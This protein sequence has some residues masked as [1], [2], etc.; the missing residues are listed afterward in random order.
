MKSPL[1]GLLMRIVKS[2]IMMLLQRWLRPQRQRPS[3]RQQKPQPQQKTLPNRPAASDAIIQVGYAPKL[4][5]DPDPGEVVWTWVTYEED[6]SRGKDRP[7]LIIGH[8]DQQLACVAL[9]SKRH[10][11]AAQ[12]DVGT[13]PWDRDRRV[14]YASIDRLLDVAPE[15]I[16]REGAIL[17]RDRF[18]QV[19]TA[20][21]EQ[22]GTVIGA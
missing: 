22:H 5:G 2:I 20:L 3:G 4:D 16:R 15:S 10:E 11:R 13:G 18:D 1:N 6:A 7:V 19:I 12:V 14:S 21:R 17:D 9:T 8:R